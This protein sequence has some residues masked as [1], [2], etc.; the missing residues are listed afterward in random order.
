MKT[1][2]LTGLYLSYWVAKAEGREPERFDRE[3]RGWIRCK[4]DFMPFDAEQWHV[5]G[6]IIGRLGIE[7]EDNGRTAVIDYDRDGVWV[8]RGDSHTI[9]AMRAY[10]LMRFGP[11]VPDLPPSPSEVRSGGT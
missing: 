11:D 9:A 4:D 8:G 10:L 2:E 7:F 1:T 5:A 3:G 6:P